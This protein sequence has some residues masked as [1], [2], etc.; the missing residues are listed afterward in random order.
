MTARYGLPDHLFGP[1]RHGILIANNIAE[2]EDGEHNGVL[3]K[4]LAEKWERV[5]RL[6][7]YHTSLLSFAE[8]AELLAVLELAMEYA[9]DNNY[10]AEYD[11]DQFPD[12][13]QFVQAIEEIRLTLQ[14]M[15]VNRS[16]V[17]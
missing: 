17:A 1:V 10:G 11:R 3:L 13:Y 2:P 6:H 8:S 14:D 16:L 12:D 5:S 4:D 7:H 9:E 15:S